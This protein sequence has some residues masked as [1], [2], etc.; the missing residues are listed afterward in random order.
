LLTVASVANDANV[1]PFTL[2]LTGSGAGGI[3]ITGVIA[4]GGTTGTTAVLIN[5]TGD[6]VFSGTNTLTG[7]IALN[8]GKL[9]ATV[10]GAFGASTNTLTFGGG[11]L[12]LRS[13]T[14]LAITYTG[15][16]NLNSANGTIFVNT[17]GA[18]N[19]LTH[20]ISGAL[21]LGTQTTTVSAGGNLNPD[22]NYGLTFSGAKT[23]AAPNSNATFTIN[24][25]GAGN[26]TLSLITGTIN[27][28][29]N[30]QTLTFNSGSGTGINSA[31]LSGAF[32]GTA[33]TL[34]L[35]GSAPVTVGALT[36]SANVVEVNS[37]TGGVYTFNGASTFTGG[38]VL[39]S[40]KLNVNTTGA[41]GTSGP[42]GNG[43]TFTINGG[44]IDNTSGSAKVLL[45]VNPITIGGDFAFG[46]SAGISTANNLTLPGAVSLGTDSTI[47]LNGL[48]ALALSGKLTNTADSVRTLTVNNGS[49]TGATSILTIG[50]IDLTGAGSTAARNNI[51]NGSGAMA[52][53]GIV[54]DGVSA[55]SGLVYSGTGV[56]TLAG[57]NSYT[58]T[59][60]VSSG[61]VRVTN[62]SG[63]GTTAAGTSVAAAG[64]L[65]VQA[66]IAGEA[67]TL[68]A[69]G[70]GAGGNGMIRN[71]GTVA[72]SLDSA[73]GLVTG[74]T[75]FGVSG[76]GNLTLS[77]VLSDATTGG[78]INKVGSGTGA[79]ILSNA[80][81]YTGVT[82]ISAGVLQ[83]A[84]MANNGAT[85][86]IGQGG[87]VPSAADLVFAGGTL[88]YLGT[89]I[90]STDRLF[91][92][93]DGNT[94]TIEN[95]SV[96]TTTSGTP[97]PLVPSA[98]KFTNT[99]S[100]AYAAS[101]AH[102]LSL[103]GS[104]HG[105]G[106]N[107]SPV[108]RIVA[109]ANNFAL[110]IN[111]HSVSNPTN[112]I[113]AGTG[114]W[115]LSGTNGYTG[116]T[117]VSAGRLVVDNLG[118]L[119]SGPISI[120][121]GGQVLFRVNGT[122]NHNIDVV[123]VGA[124]LN[125][126]SSVGGVLGALVLLNNATL[127][128]TINLNGDTRISAAPSIYGDAS[129]AVGNISGQITGVGRLEIGSGGALNAGVITLS[130]TANNYSGGTRVAAG[131]TGSGSDAVLQLGAS[132]VIPNGALAGDVNLHGNNTGGALTFRMNSFSD[133]INALVTTGAAS[134]Q[135]V[136]NGTASTTST[137][138]LGD[139]DASGTFK[140]VL[141]NGSGTL[142]ITKIGSGTQTIGRAATYTGTTRVE[143]G[144]L[145]I[146]FGGY[147]SVSSAT[148]AINNYLGTGT[149]V[150]LAGGTLKF[151][152][153]AT[154]A[155][156]S[157]NIAY[158]GNVRSIVL[159][160]V[161]GITVGQVLYVNGV[162]TSQFI[163]Q[164]EAA[165]NTI[166][167]NG[168]P[169]TVPGGTYAIGTETTGNYTHSQT[170]GSLDVSANSTLEFSGVSVTQEMI[171][172]FG[173][174]TQSVDGSILTI[175]GWSAAPNG[176][177][178]L[179]FNGVTSTF[180]A[181]FTQAEVVFSG[182]GTGYR[183]HQFGGYYEVT[184]ASIPEPTTDILILL[185]AGGLMLRRRHSRA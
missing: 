145:N 104:Y 71:S 166:Y 29:G 164:V 96:D 60:S 101:G 150:Q 37:T 167:L 21:T 54:A 27:T 141:Q 149:N 87:A 134:V 50:S 18:T 138:T 48:A 33:G 111:D 128:G 34:V 125:V 24:G 175:D 85:S 131:G 113:K 159:P 183:A 88:R 129:T 98:L 112:L 53:S 151:T 146:D 107:N 55:G 158:S 116:G 38:V 5:A 110:T 179:R 133:T 73:L 66:A 160:S 20:V 62:V 185:G 103:G 7:G 121:S 165:T 40:G 61:T 99:G 13:G 9:I 153:R 84:V 177:N 120:A 156:T 124:P 39:T 63:L 89:T 19:G 169:P 86:G 93:G 80:N 142:A 173:G 79:L 130:N 148:T 117:T 57:G 3:A 2:S 95:N 132:G 10:A 74:S 102:T 65:D 58:G 106:G 136:E 45:N 75:S 182:Y 32:T 118:A 69:A 25:N 171:I 56:L 127:S 47:T 44:V 12:E 181:L 17:A 108:T 15:A 22:T 176:A 36:T 137:L 43:G 154:G 70:A 100:V 67:L 123:G 114:V 115:V 139:N 77:G 46:T 92:I 59:T 162:A 143:E 109:N 157:Q 172:Q 72:G 49:G 30:T 6:T 91:T 14:N 119:G 81:T 147:A 135:R 144:E 23:F 31:V 97:P 76:T 16:V 126:S 105:L 42:L 184:P 11:N 64:S 155:T 163:T 82:T 41:A 68:L 83:V 94:A 161:E 168:A 178:Q 26:A 1:T 52:V 170:L 35:A 140:G 90:S 78:G 152:G 174:V 8:G 122:Y 4:N 51:F 180:T 28:G